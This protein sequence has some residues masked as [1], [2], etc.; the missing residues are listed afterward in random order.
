MVAGMDA[1]IQTRRRSLAMLGA[2][3]ALPGLARAAPTPADKTIPEAQFTPDDGST[4]VMGMEDM[5]RRMTA[6]VTINGQ[7]PFDFMVDTGTNRS[8]ISDE[9]AAQLAL[10]LGR[11]VSLHGI[12]GSREAPTVTL[13][14]FK[15]GEREATRLSLPVLPIK[16]MR[17]L[18]ILGVDGLKDQRVVLDLREAH[19]RIEP[20]SKRDTQTGDSVI[21]ARRK[22]GQLTVIDT[23]LDGLQVTVMIDT[24]AETTIGNTALQ[25]AVGRRRRAGDTPLPQATLLGATGEEAT[26]DVGG[27]PTFRVGTLKVSN[28]RVVYADLHPFTLWELI[29]KPAMIMGMDL[30]RFFDVLSLDYG[31]NEVRFTLPLQPFIDPAGDSRPS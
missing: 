31:R 23:D 18:G 22:F 28:L 5:L 4:D 2:G 14:H 10:P 17:G 24:G 3:L 29:D 21:K 1:L 20:S 11:P 13:E 15:I 26:G 30:I 12:S 8:V 7:G 9:L 19:L 16:Y 6:P 25:R 27:L